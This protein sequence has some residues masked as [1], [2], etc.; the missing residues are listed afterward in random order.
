MTKPREFS[1][2]SGP[3]SI[4]R[5]LGHPPHRN[6]YTHTHTHM[7]IQG[8]A[9]SRALTQSACTALTPAYAHSRT[10]AHTHTPPNTGEPSPTHVLCTFLLRHIHTRTYTCIDAYSHTHPCLL[11][12]AHSL[13]HTHLLSHSYSCSHAHPHSVTHTGTH[14]YTITHTLYWTSPTPT[15]LAACPRPA[16]AWP[17]LVAAPSSFPSWFYLFS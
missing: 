6:T 17:R 12:P 7:R 13:T 3:P 8:H 5:D 11:T 10:P 2:S 9:H 15:C 1:P 4:A 14:S 16:R